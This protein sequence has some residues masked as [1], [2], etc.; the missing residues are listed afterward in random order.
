MKGYFISLLLLLSVFSIHAQNAKRIYVTLDVSGSMTGNKY[1][2]ANYTTQMIVTLCD[3]DDDVYMIVYGVA[4]NL[5]KKSSPLSTIQ[6]P[7]NDLKFGK[8]KTVNS[9]SEFGDIIGFNRIYHASADKQDWLFIIGDGEWGTMSPYFKSD[10]EKFSDIIK[11]GTVNI[12]YL[13]TKHSLKDGDSDF[14]DFLSQFGV[15]DMAKS[16]INP[17][18]IKDGCDHFARKI[19]GFSET[20]LALTKSGSNC[21]SI[22]TEMPLNG[23]YLVYQDAATP[24]KLPKIETATSDGQALKA[25][26]RGTPTTKPLQTYLNEVDLSGR[27]YWVKGSNSIQANKEIQVCFDKAINLDNVRVYP[28]VEDVG[29]G[30]LIC[31]TEG[32]KLKYLDSQS[33]AICKDESK[34]RVRIELNG[35]SSKKIPEA[36]LRKTKVVIKANNKDYPAKF[37]NGGFECDIDLF[38]EET[39]YYAECDCPGYFKRVTPISKIIKSDDCEPDEPSETEVTVMPTIN[40]GTF[41]FDRLKSESIIFTIRDSLT[42]K[43]LK[44]SLFDISFDVENG[45]LY[46]DPVMHIKNDT[47][48]VLE[49]RPRGEW[50]ECFFPES[51]NIKMISTPKSGATEEYG[52]LYR[53]TVYPLHIDVVKGRTWLSRCLWVIIAL[54]VLL[55]FF[56]YLQTLMKKRRFKKNAMITPTYYDYYGNKRDAGSI[57]LRKDG[58]GAWF[59][60]WFIP[61]DERSTLNF[62]KPTTSLRFVAADSYDMVNIPKDGNIDP[63]TMK[64]SGYDPKRDQRPKEPVK[65]SNHGKIN[66]KKSDGSDDG[67]LIFSSGDATDG[68]GYRIILS[69]LMVA[70]VIAFVFLAYLL[71]RSLF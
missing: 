21:I 15:V 32:G 34:A 17:Q 25:T 5:S 18:T 46:E 1:A 6:K 33:Y 39:Q 64:I 4:E 35:K 19:L 7:M 48:I 55:L 8:P 52:K 42:N 12:C 54:I 16:D 43:V 10:R 31:T 30:S 69:L 27:V 28:V 22:K 53:K 68:A 62:D 59:S 11:S 63:S 58:F 36:L 60:R 14:T 66:V 38:N 24:N 71:I 3:D 9:D 70:A 29:F 45:L 47:L 57:Y 41:T 56:I 2:L 13:Q 37:N 40:L 65:L 50:C 51:L 44:P 26:L 49:V 23:F 61:G 20:P 67:Y